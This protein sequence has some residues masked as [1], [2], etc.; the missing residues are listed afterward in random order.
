MFPNV[1]LLIAALL[2]SVFALSFGFGVFAALGVNREPLGRLPAGTSALQLVANQAAPAAWGAPYGPGFRVSEAQPGAV[3]TDAQ[4]INASAGR[5]TNSLPNDQNA[6]ATGT[7]KAEVSNASPSAEPSPVSPAAP[8]PPVPSA[9]EQPAASAITPAA[10]LALTAT[11]PETPSIEP[12][13]L[14]PAAVIATKPAEEKPAAAAPT[15]AAVEPTAK[16]APSGAQ[17]PDVTGSVPGA[18]APQVKAPEKLTR[19]PERR[20]TRKVVRKLAERHVVKK[21]PTRPISMTAN[22]R[23]TNKTS[24]F[25]EPVFQSAPEPFEQPPATNRR[26]AK[27]TAKSTTTTNSLAW[28]SAQ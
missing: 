19:T 14:Q 2:A 28:P 21:R 12:Q 16:P 5:E 23:S 15:V 8:A 20:V 6:W 9:T 11:A 10:P 25:Q 3:A 1:R 17:S 4:P 22:A 13:G 18:A 24:T 27:K 26:A 7:I